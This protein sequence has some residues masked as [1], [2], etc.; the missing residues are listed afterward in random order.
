MKRTKTFHIFLEEALKQKQADWN[1]CRFSNHGCNVLEEK[2]KTVGL[3]PKLV[4]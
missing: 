3:E 4:S 1:G 2:L